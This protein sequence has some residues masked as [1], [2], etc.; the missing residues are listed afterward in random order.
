MVIEI[1]FG[2]VMI[3]VFLTFLND[4]GRTGFHPIKR[5]YGEL[6]QLFH[7]Y[8]YSL[9]LVL[10]LSIIP[11]YFNH[12]MVTAGVT[13]LILLSLLT[14]N[15]ILHWQVSLV[16]LLVWFMLCSLLV[17]SLLLIDFSREEPK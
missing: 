12:Y 17:H 11:F 15:G 16:L 3:G 2:V 13:S 6:V 14:S 8:L 9:L 1:S 10:L 5:N 4:L 7:Y